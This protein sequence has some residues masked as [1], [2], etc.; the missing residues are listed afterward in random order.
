MRTKQG[1]KMKTQ[2]PSQHSE[3]AQAALKGVI[4]AI[5]V[6]GG[7]VAELGSSLVSPLEKRKRQ[8]AEEI[9]ITLLELQS[10][11]A[12]LPKD[13]SDD[14]TFVTALLKATGTALAT[15]RKE[16]R[17]LLGRFLVAVG[18]KAISD[19]ELQHAILKL[20]DDL[21]VGHMDVL[22][23]LDADSS[24]IAGLEKLDEVYARYR[25]N[26]HGT[27][28]RNTFRWIIA[29]LSARMVIHLGDIEDM[30]EFASLAETL[31]LE[32]SR[33]RP[34]QITHLG[35]QF[36]VL[37]RNEPDRPPANLNCATVTS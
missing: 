16:K 32:S 13:L 1:E 17:E 37:L 10:K 23:F 24:R 3:L 34:L 36:L 27:L 21:S 11:H 9:E 20:V 6:I 29:D 18:S 31:A 2:L 15:H 28:A 4:S 35:K 7:L 14:P 12:R 5:P 25:E 33:V 19:E 22:R 8:W 26:Y 30:D